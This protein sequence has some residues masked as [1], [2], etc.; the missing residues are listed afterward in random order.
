[1]S[2][3]PQP[4]LGAKQRIL[5]TWVG[6][7]DPWW[8]NPRTKRQEPGPILS[9]LRDRSFDTVYLLFN[10]DSRTEDFR[11]RATD[12]LRACQKHFPKVRVL[13]KP[14]DVYSVVDHAELFRVTNDLCQNVIRDEGTEGKQYFVFL[15]PGTPPMQTVWVLLV[16]S[17][18]LPATMLQGTAADL[19]TPGAP[20]V[21]EV[22]LS[23]PNFP[24]VVSPGETVRQ[25]GILEAR[26]KTISLEKL[27]LQAQLKESQASATASGGT[28]PPGFSLPE[29]LRAEE[30]ANY[31]RALA[32]TEGKASDAAQLLGVEP[33]TFRARAVTLGL[34]ER[35]S[36]ARRVT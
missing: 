6:S 19:V 21:R 1:M 7:R 4:A 10:L 11:E 25:L 36:R 33:H 13:Q 28:I 12:V 24:Q 35:R 16:Q 14:L 34:R 8:V 26:L 27:E 15:S 17:G 30:A 22:D 2:S 32:Q 31:A 5:L 23:L 29:H 3:L 9:L 20:R 18:L